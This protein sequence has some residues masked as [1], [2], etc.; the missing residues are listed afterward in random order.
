MTFLFFVDAVLLCFACVETLCPLELVH[1]NDVLYCSVLQCCGSLYVLRYFV[2]WNWCITAK[3]ST[4]V[5]C[6][7]FVFL[8]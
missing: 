1:Q 7:S 2:L 6:N 4:V 5:C 3:C 8:N